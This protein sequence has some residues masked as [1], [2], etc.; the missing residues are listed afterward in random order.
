MCIASFPRSKK[1]KCLLLVV[2]IGRD[3]WFGE[4]SKTDKYSNH[5]GNMHDV[6]ITLRK[7]KVSALTVS[8]CNFFPPVA[9]AV[10]TPIPL[11]WVVAGAGTGAA[12]AVIG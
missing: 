7:S 1:L 5:T 9:S 8:A 6:Q 2:L 12:G 4:S 10:T 11:A 3:N